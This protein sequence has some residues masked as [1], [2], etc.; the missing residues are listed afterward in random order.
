MT[1]A[2][3]TIN[4]YTGTPSNQ[5]MDLFGDYNFNVI[6]NSTDNNWNMVSS[7]TDPIHLTST[8]GDFF[9]NNIPEDLNLSG[10]TVTFNVSFL[11]DGASSATITATDATDGT[12]TAATSPTVLIN[13]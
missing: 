9:V 2:P 11:T 4:G 7:G 3:N 8:S 13:Q 6:V 1:A 10:G 12:K 5:T